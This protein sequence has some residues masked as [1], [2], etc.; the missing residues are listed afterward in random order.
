[1]LSSWQSSHSLLSAVTPLVRLDGLDYGM[2]SRY[3]LVG[4]KTNLFSTR[5]CLRMQYLNYG[6]LQNKPHWTFGLITV[7]CFQI[8]ICIITRDGFTKSPNTAVKINAGVAGSE[9]RAQGTNKWSKYRLFNSSALVEFWSK[10][11]SIQDYFLKLSW[12]EFLMVLVKWFCF[13]FTL[14]KNKTSVSIRFL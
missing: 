3:L 13:R 6:I 4:P 10:R 9:E 14:Y 2:F 5:K 7:N 1:M 12:G 8:T 11:G